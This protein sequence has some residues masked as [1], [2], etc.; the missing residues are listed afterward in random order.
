MIISLRT[1]V[2]KANKGIIGFGVNFLGALQE[3]FCLDEIIF[4]KTYFGHK[5]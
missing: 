5:N 2:G 4:G 3:I 1:E